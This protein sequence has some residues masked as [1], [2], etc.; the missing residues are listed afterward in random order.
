MMAAANRPL[1]GGVF[2]MRGMFSAEPFTSRNYPQLLQAA[3]HNV[4]GAR[5]DRQ[6]PHELIGEL[7]LQYGRA[8]T[9]SMAAEVYVAAAGEPAIGPVMYLHRP[10]AAHDPAA[11]LGHHSQDVTHTTFGVV[12]VGVFTRAV[13]LEGSIF[14]GRHPDDVHTNLE[15]SDA[16]PDSYAARLTLNPSQSWNVAASAAYIA[17]AHDAAQGGGGASVA[18][19]DRRLAA[20]H[21]T[22]RG[23][24]RMV[25]CDCVRRELARRRQSAAQRSSRE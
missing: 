23:P 9:R 18:A 11:P 10:S 24:R 19:S 16:R 4:S 1:G 21:A 3:Q 6:H 17:P 14:S 13:K 2:R 15:F 25:Q 20:T 7:A 5:S 8:L 22:A 12:T